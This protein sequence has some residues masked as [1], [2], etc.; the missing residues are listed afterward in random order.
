MLSIVAVNSGRI[1]SAAEAKLTSFIWMTI[2]NNGLQFII[3]EEDTF[4]EMISAVRK[5]SRYYKLPGREMMWCPLIDNCFDNHIKNQREKLLIRADIWGLRFQ[6]DGAKIKDTAIINILVGGFNLPVSVKIILEC[7]GHITG[8]HKKDA[9]F[10]AEIFFDPMNDLD[11]EKTCEPTYI[12]WSQCVQKVWKILK[13]VY[14]MLLYIV[15]A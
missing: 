3:G 10:V 5:F 6:G 9:K 12:R 2:F 15:G 7:T 14:P 13:V 8:G 11:P 4:R 1:L